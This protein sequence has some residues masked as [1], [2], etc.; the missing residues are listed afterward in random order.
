MVWG[1]TDVYERNNIRVFYKDG[2]TDFMKYGYDRKQSSQPWHI[3]EIPL[4]VQDIT[5][6][7]PKVMSRYKYLGLEV[8]ENKFSVYIKKMDDA[9][10]VGLLGMLNGYMLLDVNMTNPVELRQVL[11]HE[12]MHYTQDF[13]IS[14]NPGNSFWMEAH[15]TLS[16]RIVWNDKEVP[17]CESEQLMLTGRTSDIS[18]FNFLSNSWDYWDKSLATNNL[19]GNIHYNYL[20]GTFLHYMRSEREK[21]TKLEPATLLK[22]TSWLGSWR[23]YLGSYTSK[24]MNAILGD[25]YE[26]FVKFILSGKNENFTLINKNGNPYSFIQNPKNNNVFTHPVRYFFKEGGEMVQKDEIAISVPYMASKVVLLENTNTDTMILVNYK[27]KHNTDYDHLVYHVSYDF[28]SREMTFLDISDSAEY[29]FLLEPRNEENTLKQFQDYSILLLINKEYIGASALIKDFNASFELTAMPVLD[30]DRIAMLNIY[31]GSSPIKHNFNDMQDYISIGSPDPAFLQKVTEFNVRM[32]DGESS[33]KILNDRTYQIKTQYTLVID[34]GLIKGMPAMK[35][36]TV[37]TQTLD[38]D[39]V[40]G[41][42]KISEAEHKF[43][44]LHTYISFVEGE[45]GD[46]VE[47]VVFD[48]YIDQIE[49]RTKTYWL[50]EIMNFIQPASINSG[51]EEAYGKNIVMFETGNTAETRQVVSKIEASTRIQS[52]NPGG[53]FSSEVNSEYE[54]TDY[55]GS[56]FILRLILKSAE[57]KR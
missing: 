38:H 42:I 52:F 50:S 31:N 24:H 17:L 16:D 3:A 27:R 20:A 18:I 14:A 10:C 43:H 1:F 55:S 36:S 19:L 30:V 44:R 13:Y 45:D 48:S 22:E 33:Q 15:A 56:G 41:T 47:K 25:E 12:Y 9:G 5:E 11:A 51:W 2:D 54:N 34:Q 23:T 53:E 8:P 57:E 46:V 21:T 26:E 39:L 37:Y 4:L 32:V 49:E 28:K 29:N 7:L 6:Y 40:S 35:D